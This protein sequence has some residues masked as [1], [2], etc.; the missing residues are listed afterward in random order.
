MPVRLTGRGERGVRMD[1]Q[2]NEQTNERRCGALVS[3]RGPA[4][5]LV[6][7]WWAVLSPGQ[8]AVSPWAV[9][10]WAATRPAVASTIASLKPGHPEWGSQISQAT[11]TP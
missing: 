2:T 10:S 8:S 11:S 9:T 3:D 1:E 5:F 6:R 7:W 4:F